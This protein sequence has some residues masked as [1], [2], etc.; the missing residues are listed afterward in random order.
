[1]TFI[2]CNSDFI[3]RIFQFPLKISRDSDKPIEKVENPGKSK[4]RTGRIV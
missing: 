4:I 1:M 3:I 2:R